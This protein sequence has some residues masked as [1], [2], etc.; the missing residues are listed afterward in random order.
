MRSTKTTALSW[1]EPVGC[2]ARLGAALCAQW[3]QKILILILDVKKI[4]IL[5]FIKILI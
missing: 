2:E 1:F 5:D 4:L 3:P